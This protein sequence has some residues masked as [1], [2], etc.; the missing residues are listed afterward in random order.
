MTK[1]SPKDSSS[2]LTVDQIHLVDQCA[3]LERKC[4]DLYRLFAQRCSGYPGLQKLWMKTA[5][6][7]EHHAL[8]FEML[9]RMRGAG[10]S[11]VNA[12][13]S[14]IKKVFEELESLMKRVENS[15]LSPIDTLK[16]GIKVEKSLARYHPDAAAT[17]SDPEM[18]HL[19]KF[20][21]S[22]D[23]DHVAA[24][25]RALGKLQAEMAGRAD[26]AA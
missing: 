1:G 18:A 21:M 11:G 19:I 10:L 20:M 24:L 3:L 13:A 6:E 8:Q 2:T 16:L 9:G 12:D 15:S 7:E 22:H 17:C 14:S 25:E 23:V 26:K 5:L 4:G